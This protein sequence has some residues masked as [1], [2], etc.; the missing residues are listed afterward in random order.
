MKS[1]Y[2]FFLILL[3]SICVSCS[4]TY[5][6]QINSD[7]SKK[8]LDPNIL[9]YN[10]NI[11]DKSEV[12]QV[13]TI[14]ER[15]AENYTFRKLRMMPNTN[16]SYIN[17]RDIQKFIK[18]KAPKNCDIIISD[19]KYVKVDH[20]WML[21][22]IQQLMELKQYFKIKFTEEAFDCD[23]FANTAVVVTNIV[24]SYSELKAQVLVGRIDVRQEISWGGI[25]DGYHA[26][27]FFVSEK[28]IFIFEPQNGQ[29]I[30]IQRYPNKNTIYRIYLD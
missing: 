13:N 19:E 3:S 17:M 9:E 21:E 23:N 27:C 20:Q 6:T 25:R 29:V 2:K 24:A 1:F 7:L 14:I 28:G 5:D 10:K 26:L 12:I 15:P 18:D 8:S 30:D 11:F 4:T 22:T 16:T